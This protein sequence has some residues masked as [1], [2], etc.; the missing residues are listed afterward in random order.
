[1]VFQIALDGSFYRQHDLERVHSGAAEVPEGGFGYL[2]KGDMEY[3]D[4]VLLWDEIWEHDVDG[5]ERQVFS[6]LDHFEPEELC[7]HWALTVVES[8][9]DTAH[10]DWTHANSLVLSEDG[11]AWYLGVRHFDALLKID[12]ESGDLL[13]TLGGPYSD[14][15]ATEPG[16]ELSHP[17]LSQVEEGRALFFDNGSHH[18]PPGSRLVQL[19]FDDQAMEVSMES[20]L[21]APD[22]SYIPELG[23]AI[24]TPE[25]NLM[26][27][28]TSLGLVEEYNADLEP[29]WTLGLDLGFYTGRIVL[30]DSLQP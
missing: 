21:R 14:F 23:D 20:E 19:V 18:S 2:R 3:Q 22:G 26:G 27:S 28:W 9:D 8:Q 4:G 11:S 16:T 15:Q 6:L 10:F 12:R 30:L 5:Q 17:H 1:V 29:V 7:S 25:G 24:R 13:W